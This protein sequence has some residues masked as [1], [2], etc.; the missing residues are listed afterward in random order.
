MGRTLQGPE[1]AERNHLMHQ[2]EAGEE[3]AGNAIEIVTLKKYFLQVLS[4]FTMLTAE[5]DLLAEVQITIESRK[6]G[7]DLK[8]EEFSF[9]DYLTSEQTQQLN[10]LYRSMEMYSRINLDVQM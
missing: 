6:G 1:E 9:P 8:W 7:T 10:K 3:E 4:T 5:G 2:D